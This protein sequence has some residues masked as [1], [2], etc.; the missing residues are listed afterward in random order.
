TVLYISLGHA[1]LFSAGP[2]G[3]LLTG[4]CPRRALH[5]VCASTLFCAVGERVRERE[6]ELVSVVEKE[7]ER[8]RE[9]YKEQKVMKQ[10]KEVSVK[11]RCDCA[12]EERPR[13]SEPAGWN[14]RVREREFSYM[15][16]W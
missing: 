12:G 9:S 11:R 5:R 15:C 16:V 10:E 14:A 13:I 4:F 3:C 1:S 6:R 7:R 2:G 8:G